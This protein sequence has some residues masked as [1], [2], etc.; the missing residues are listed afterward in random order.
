MKELSV[1]IPCLDEEKTIR[2]CI[3][4]CKKVFETLKI[5]G[6][7]IVTDNGSTDRT[8]EI[9]KA[10]G[11]NVVT[12]EKRGYGANLRNGFSYAK[13]KFMVPHLPTLLSTFL[14]C[15]PITSRIATTI[16]YRIPLSIYNLLPRQEPYLYWLRLH[17]IWRP[18]I[19]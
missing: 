4:K 6:E 5:D 9:A 7:I 15:L 10:Q 3:E 19:L 2:I 1:V 18:P 13:G 12:C 8:V 16:P 11:V 14:C 17:C